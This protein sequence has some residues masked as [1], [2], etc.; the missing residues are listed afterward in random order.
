MDLFNFSEKKYGGD[1]QNHIFE[2]WKTA[3][4]MSNH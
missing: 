4:E 2:Q 1:Y 3:V